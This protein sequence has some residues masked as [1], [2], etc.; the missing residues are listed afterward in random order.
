MFRELL[1]WAAPIAALLSFLDGGIGPAAAG[2]VRF[3]RA[4]QG[5]A[6]LF[7]AL[8]WSAAA[9]SALRAIVLFELARR[10]VPARPES[11]GKIRM[12]LEKF[13]APAEFLELCAL[14]CCF[15][16]RWALPLNC[17]QAR[18]SRLRFCA[19]ALI[20]NF[21]WSALLYAAAYHLTAANFPGELG[22]LEAVR[23]LPGLLLTAVVFAVVART[24][25]ARFVSRHAQKN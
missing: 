8:F 19:A 2:I 20:G 17:G 4:E 10:G 9:G 16:F 11:S 12:R 15:A 23:T 3:A 21:C 6:P 5:G 25:A 7:D 14:Q 18:M 24:A 13:G 1:D 22:R